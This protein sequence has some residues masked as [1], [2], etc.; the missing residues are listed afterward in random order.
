MFLLS[1][2]TFQMY[3]FLELYFH[4]YANWKVQVSALG[5]WMILGLAIVFIWLIETRFFTIKTSSFGV[6]E[7]DPR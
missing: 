2:L 1:G 4:T 3:Q 6:E 5:G 7:D